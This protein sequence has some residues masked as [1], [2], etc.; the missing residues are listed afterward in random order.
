[1]F[2]FCKL[3]GIYGKKVFFKFILHYL[4]LQESYSEHAKKTAIEIANDPVPHELNNC[5]DTKTKC[6]LYWCLI[7]FIDWRYS[8]SCWYFRSCFVKYAPLT[9]SG[10]GLGGVQLY[11]RPY[12][13]G[14]SHCVSDQIQNLQNCYTT[15]N[16]NLRGEGATDRKTPASKS[17]YRLIFLDNDIWHCFLSV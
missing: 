12:S 16:K 15:P 4:Q 3:T 13:A 10:R 2:V 14:V 7:E 6:R 1:M 17:L 8:Q 11:W 9:L 5:K